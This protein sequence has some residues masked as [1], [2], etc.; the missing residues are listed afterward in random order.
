MAPRAQFCEQR[1]GGKGIREREEK[2]KP[3]LQRDVSRPSHLRSMM[4]MGIMLCLI[5]GDMAEMQ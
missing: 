1:E 2:K 4:E 5:S 3:S